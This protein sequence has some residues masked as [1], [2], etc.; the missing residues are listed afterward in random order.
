VASVQNSAANS[1][2]GLALARHFL[3]GT[4]GGMG[5][6]PYNASNTDLEKSPDDKADEVLER[7]FD[8][9]SQSDA[10]KEGCFWAIICLFGV[11]LGAIL[12][13]LIHGWISI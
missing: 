5:E 13:A 11:I 2:A 7:F 6:N 1:F 4:M 9:W 10:E 12:F 3:R 8:L